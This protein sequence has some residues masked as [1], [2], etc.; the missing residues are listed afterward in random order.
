V[1]P[2][3]LQNDR[4]KSFKFRTGITDGKMPINTL[5]SGVTSGFPGTQFF[6]EPL[7]AWDSAITETL[8]RECRQFNFSNIKPTAMFGRVVNLKVF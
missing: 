2:K 7:N 8:C 3:T 6:I 5:L 4:V 1:S